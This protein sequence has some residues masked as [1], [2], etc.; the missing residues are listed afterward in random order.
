[1]SRNRWKHSNRSMI[2]RISWNRRKIQM[3]WNYGTTYTVNWNYSAAI[4]RGTK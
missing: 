1:M 2:Y 4:R 3:K